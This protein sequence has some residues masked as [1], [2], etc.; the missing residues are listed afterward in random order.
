MVSDGA[1]L[2]AIDRRFRFD[3]HRDKIT[4]QIKIV[5]LQ[6]DFK[7]G[8]VRLAG[9]RVNK[10]LSNMYREWIFV[11]NISAAGIIIQS[12]SLGDS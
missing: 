7:R 1:I 9:M 8:E 2:I 12:L 10:R 6:Q 3:L 5:Q 11:N 4:L